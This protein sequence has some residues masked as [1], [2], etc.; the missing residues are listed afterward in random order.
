MIKLKPATYSLADAFEFIENNK[1]SLARTITNKQLNE[2]T[3]INPVFNEP[4]PQGIK[5]RLRHQSAQSRV[6]LYTNL[7]YPYFSI[8]DVLEDFKLHKKE[9][10]FD[11]LIDNNQNI[12]YQSHEIE[13]NKNAVKSWKAQFN[14]ETIF[15]YYGLDGDNEFAPFVGIFKIE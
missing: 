2:L 13:F 4:T 14:F 6:L 9:F 8:G 1:Y 15:Q 7:G 11:Y 12:T 3:E 10:F 5:V